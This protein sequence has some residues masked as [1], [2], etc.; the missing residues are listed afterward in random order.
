MARDDPGDQRRNAMT[1]NRTDHRSLRW[2]LLST[3][4]INDKILGSGAAD[5]V[6]VA[7]RDGERAAEY[8]GAHGIPRAHGSYEALLADPAVDSVYISLPNALHLPWA[9]R[10]LRAGK[11]VLCEKPLSRRAQEVQDAFALAADRGLL[12]AEGFMWRHHPQ[13][14]RIQALIAD[15]AIGRLRLIRSEFGGGAAPAGNPRLARALDGGA[16]MDVGCYCVSGARTLAGGEPRAVSAQRAT[17]GDGVDLLLTGLLRF[18]DEL[19][20]VFDCAFLDPERCGLEA[21]GE[22]GS[23]RLLD[24]WHGREPVIELRRLGHD[25]ERIV[26]D[27]VDSYA[28]Q[29]ADF[30]AAVRGER[31][32]LLGRD[33]ALGQ[34]RAI[35]ALYRSA[36]GGE[37]TTVAP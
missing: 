30:A 20:A 22:G 33:D 27:P 37:T 28:L 13:V 4:R 25:I 17:G 26:L 12:L 16:L 10:A 32:P 23:V 19:L 3:A 11:H 2:G 1:T 29:L 6:A 18:D 24:P 35:E 34:A 8:A 15:G 21:I 36:E 14:A 5:V 31:A 9:E 7:S